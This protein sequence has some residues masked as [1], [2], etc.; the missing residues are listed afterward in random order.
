MIAVPDW[1]N[2]GVITTVLAPPLPEITIFEFGTRI[3]LE[4][5]AVTT[6]LFK[7]VFSSFIVKSIGLLTVL[8]Q[9]VG[10][11]LIVVI[12]GG[13]LAETTVIL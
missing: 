7:A 5:V 9:I 1:F 10:G 6:K 12:V 11:L 2:A 8:G 4:D 3:V 13:I